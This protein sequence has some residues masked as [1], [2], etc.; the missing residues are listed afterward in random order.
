MMATAGPFILSDAWPVWL[1]AIGVAAAGACWL[2]MYRLARRYSPVAE[3]PGLAG[4]SGRILLVAARLVLAYAAVWLCI[5][6]LGKGFLLTTSLSAWPIAAGAAGAGELLIWLYALERRVAPRRTGLALTALRL[7]LV[8]LLVALLLQP[9][10]A[11]VTTERRKRPLAIILDESASMGIRDQRLDPH[12]KLRLGEFFSVAAAKRP[13]QLERQGERLTALADKLATEAAWLDRLAQGRKDTARSRLIDRR[14]KLHELLAAWAEEVRECADDL[15]K[16]GAEAALS[17]N[18]QSA[19]LDAKATL[20]RQALPRLTD[21]AGWTD[22][23]SES[24]LL[25]KLDSLR[26]ALHRAVAD[27]AGSAK[28]LAKLSKQMDRALYE[29]LSETQRDEIDAVARLP[30]RQLARAALLHRRRWGDSDKPRSLL[31]LLA[32]KYEL[33]VYTFAA[34]VAEADT[35]AWTDPLATSEETHE[36]DA[37]DAEYAGRTDLSAALSEVASRLGGKD[38]AGVIL[39]SDGQHNGPDKPE[40]MAAQFGGQGAALSSVI[41]GAAKAPTDAAIVA[42]DAPETV[43]LDDRMFINVD[44]KLDG[45]DGGQAKVTLYAGEEAVDSK[46]VRA[47][48]DVFRT[49]VQLADKPDKV[50]LHPYRIAVAPLAADM[51]EAFDENNSYSLSLSV[52]DDKTNILLLDSR[53]RWEFR[54]LKNLFS[55]RD[56]TVRLQYVLT[57]PDRYTG[58]PAGKKTPA[59]ASRPE[60]ETEA[61]ALPANEAEWMKFDVIIVGDLPAADLPGD[62][63]E[64]LKRF[65]ADRGGTVIFIAGPQA[66]PADHAA[67]PLAEMIPLDFTAAKPHAAGAKANTRGFR[68]TLT[69]AGAD[70]VVMRQHVRPEESARVWKSLPPVFWRSRFTHAGPASTVLAYARDADAPAWLAEAPAPGESG[71]DLERRRREYRR[72]R[73]LVTIA[74][75]GLGK[76]MMLSFDRTW[77]LRYRVGDTRHHKFWGQVIRWAV[78]GELPAGT[79]LVKLGADRTRYPPRSRPRVRAKIVREDYSPVITDQVAVKVLRDGQLVARTPMKYVP[80]SPGIYTATL[81]ELPAGGYRLELDAPAARA[82]LAGEGLE[83]V[84]TEI[85]IDPATPSEQIELAANADLLGRLANLSYNGVAAK[86]HQLERIIAALPAGD[87]LQQHRSELSLKQ[88]WPPWALLAL[89]CVAA[90]TEW[91]LRKKVG[92]A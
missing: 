4:R 35:S 11:S 66:M 85:T 42:I 90:T 74:P 18:L 10:W 15:D 52:V 87:A 91:I 61:T 13:H 1:L 57:H 21:A 26:D 77:R 8:A 31:E 48:G 65:T 81:G 64:M 60:G 53:P 23:D 75:H 72:T 20:S 73:A 84:A 28:G 51:Q 47:A 37:V 68:I 22:E 33:S 7:A 82:L 29:S 71:A 45:M 63:P 38:M 25:S 50:G 3:G 62:S 44:L 30:R 2:G 89:F 41:M 19:L 69:P 12:E 56:K 43:Y 39:F 79:H 27:L 55:G 59:S 92:L 86:A 36:P 54:Y 16:T 83:T 32:D 40:S 34:T 78:A 24:A 70:H 6:I 88:G 76:V 49:R 46:T 17:G 14:E 5:Q 9:V 58:Q 80:D 67:G